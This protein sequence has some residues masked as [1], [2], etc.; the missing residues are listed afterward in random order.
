[1]LLSNGRA[2]K[3]EELMTTLKKDIHCIRAQWRVRVMYAWM[4][5][6]ETARIS[7]KEV[8]SNRLS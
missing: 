2:S 1:M 6:L 5:D 8:M 4:E 3:K 7:E